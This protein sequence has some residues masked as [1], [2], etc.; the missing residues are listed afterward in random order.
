[1]GGYRN[2]AGL[3]NGGSAEKVLQLFHKTNLLNFIN[4][5]DLA[6]IGVTMLCRYFDS[7]VK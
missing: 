5:M 1:M 6:C 2:I 4:V 3:P 7:L